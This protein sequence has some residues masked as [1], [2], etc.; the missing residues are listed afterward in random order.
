M[1]APTSDITDSL[2]GRQVNDFV[3]CCL[4][5]GSSETDTGSRINAALRGEMSS[6]RIKEQSESVNWFSENMIEVSRISAAVRLINRS[7]DKSK[8]SSKKLESH[9]RVGS[10]SGSGSWPTLDVYS[11]TRSFSISYNQ[12]PDGIHV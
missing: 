8:F 5:D 10:V 1:N 2:R 6:R 12:W 11:S 4:E 7:E 9:L 3:L